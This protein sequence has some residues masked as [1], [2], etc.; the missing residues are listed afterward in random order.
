MHIY[1]KSP[2][3]GVNISPTPS[4]TEYQSELSLR[5]DILLADYCANSESAFSLFRTYH[6]TANREGFTPTS[7]D[8]RLVVM[9]Q[10]MTGQK[11]SFEKLKK[12]AKSLL[13]DV[14]NADPLAKSRILSTHPKVRDGSRKFEDITL[15]DCQHVLAIE[16]GFDSW[17]KLKR[18]LI[19]LKA[20]SRLVTSGKSIDGPKAVHIRCGSDIGQTLKD[21]GF[22]GDFLEVINPFAMGPVLPSSQKERSYELRS[23]YID[24]VLGP[25]ISSEKRANI[26]KDLIKEEQEVDTLRHSYQSVTL[27]F[28]HDAFD[29]LCLAYL[30]HKM[31]DIGPELPFSLDLVQIDHFPGFRKFIG[32]GQL[33][34]QPESLA[35]LYQQRLPVTFDMINFG[36]AIWDAY[37]SKDPTSLWHLSQ[38]K[39]A[40]LPL[41]QK[42]MLRMLSELPALKNGLGLTEQLALEIIAEE[43]NMVARRVF[44]FSLA[45]KDPQP[46]HGDVMFFAT[47][48]ALWEAETPALKITGRIEAPHDHGKEVLTLTPMGEALLKGEKNWLKVN[49]IKRWVGGVEINS[50]KL[51][52]WYFDGNKPVFV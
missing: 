22:N 3:V 4:A 32:L 27:W 36:K 6:P 1:E 30:L 18:H 16:C 23:Q 48:K 25:Y 20:A 38:R 13:K 19:A 11:F 47:L 15:V 24:Q 41:M 29:Q 7:L 28:E 50:E 49:N 39:N 10:N 12:D 35:L 17:P 52:N 31:A 21:A 5:A 9:R 45:E 46:Y 2:I 37:T 42:A 40:P 8:A 14:K 26:R 33:I 51:Q 44:L 34:D 43:G